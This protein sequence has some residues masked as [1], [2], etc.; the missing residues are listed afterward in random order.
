[1]G[2]APQQVAVTHLGCLGNGFEL[3]A[4]PWRVCVTTEALGPIFPSEG[5]QTG[6]SALRFIP[7]TGTAFL[8]L[9]D[10]AAQVTVADQIIGDR[11]QRPFNRGC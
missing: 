8:R 1:M 2:C 10:F 6:F 7:D 3:G 9:L 4:Q 11:S 5:A